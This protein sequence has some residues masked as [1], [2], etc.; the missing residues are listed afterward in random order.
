VDSTARAGRQAYLA[1]QLHTD[2]AKEALLADEVGPV[3]R[4]LL[5][6]ILLQMGYHG[7]DGNVLLPHHAPEVGHR[8]L[9]RALRANILLSPVVTV[10]P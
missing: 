9:Q 1:L 2:G 8:V 6:A 7:D 10:K 4:A 5:L 3:A